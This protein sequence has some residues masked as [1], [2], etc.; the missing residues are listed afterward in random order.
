MFYRGVVED[1]NSPGK[2]GKVRVRVF[3]F[4]DD[5]DSDF[6]NVDTSHLPWAEVMG[7]TSFGLIGGNG[8][9]SVLRQGTWVWVFFEQDDHNRPIVVGTISAIASEKVTGNFSDPA[10]VH[11][12]R[13]GPD[14]HP[15]V[16]SKYPNLAT[17]E[18]ESGHLIELDDSQGD[19]RIKITHK[20]GALILIDAGGNINIQTGANENI[21]IGG[22]VNLSVT[23]NVSNNV[24]GNV[25]YSVGGN[26]KVTASRIDLN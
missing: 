22:N 2:D 5:S 24:S 10:G 6:E 1:N 13:L 21:T 19:E 18:T 25:T 3:G 12:K 23:G 11:P 9:S 15:L 20:T 17:L 7:G 26:F 14:F 4:H 8:I 16:G